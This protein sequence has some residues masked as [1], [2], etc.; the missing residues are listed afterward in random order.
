MKDS[1]KNK[2]I[3][4]TERFE[5]LSRLISTPDVIAHQ[6]KYREY[7]KEYAKLEPV[8]QK[9][10]QFQAVQTAYDEAQVLLQEDDTEMRALA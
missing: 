10:Q 8:V 9:F 1:I 6:E 7:S 5:E 2:L 4:L 3:K